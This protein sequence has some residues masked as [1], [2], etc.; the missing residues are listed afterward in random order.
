L[1]A[2]LRSQQSRATELPNCWRSVQ[3]LD[4]VDLYNLCKLYKVKPDDLPLQAVLSHN[5]AG[6]RQ[7]PCGG[8]AE[9]IHGMV[10]MEIN[11]SSQSH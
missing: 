7:Q 9:E 2:I 3:E 5:Q 4:K 11:T 1:L 6:D 10:A 8:S